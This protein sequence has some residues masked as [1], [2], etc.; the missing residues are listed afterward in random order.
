[1]ALNVSLVPQ[2]ALNAVV[3]SM[4]DALNKS[5]HKCAKLSLDKVTDARSLGSLHH[6]Q[7]TLVTKPG[8][9]SFKATV[10]RMGGSLF[11]V[12]GDIIRTNLYRND[13]WC[14]DNFQI[15]PFCYCS[16]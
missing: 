3:A 14:V 4:N 5:S 12:Q 11:K 10:K 7:V 15:K 9:G 13:S 2:V 8:G 1:V 16:S 6:L